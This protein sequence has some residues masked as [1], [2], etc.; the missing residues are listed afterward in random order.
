MIKNLAIAV[1]V[2]SAIIFHTNC[3]TSATRH[4]SDTPQRISR[5][6]QIKERTTR[7]TDTQ[8]INSETPNLQRTRSAT[9]RKIISRSNTGQTV[10]SRPSTRVATRRATQNNANV[11][12]SSIVQTDTVTT[13]RPLNHQQ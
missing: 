7:G 11:A 6:Q 1:A 10:I 4:D 2:L 12:R 8:R 13:I 9:N 5:T 3:A